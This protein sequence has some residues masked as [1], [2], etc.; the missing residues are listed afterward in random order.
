MA[1]DEVVRLLASIDRRLALLTVTQE[2]DLR[3]RL[4]AFLE[5]D[6]RVAMFEGIDG[7]R[8]LAELAK[9]GGVTE[10]A[11]RNFV[12]DLLGLGLVRRVDRPD[13]K[14]LI[15]EHDHRA[16]LDWY[17]TRASAT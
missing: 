7:Q 14:G 5:T 17:F 9:L 10:R 1:D 8:G 12:N 16:I 4:H 2:Q 11:A 15:V 13:G 6:P 3:E